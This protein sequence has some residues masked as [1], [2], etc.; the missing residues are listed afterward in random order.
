MTFVVLIP[1]AFAEWSDFV[2]KPIDNGVFVDLFSSYERD[3]IRTDGRSLVR[4]DT[5]LREKVT[6][7]SGGYFYHPRFLLYQVSLGGI[8]KQE[9][10]EATSL[11]EAGWKSGSGVEYDGRLLFLPEHPY[12]LELFARRFEPLF[13]E[14]SATQHNN[15]ETSRGAVFKYRQKPYFFHAQY[16][17]NVIESVSSSS[18]VQ[19]LGLGGEYFK[20]FE[21][22]NQFSLSAAYNPSRFSNSAGLD[23]RSTEKQLNHSFD[24]QRVNM[25]VNIVDNT[26]DQDSRA[27]GSYEDK[28]FDLYERLSVHLPHNFRTEISYRIRD[29]QARFTDPGAS[30]S[31]ELSDVGEDLQINVIHR[32]YQSLDTRYSFLRNTRDSSNGDISGLSH[33]LVTNYTKLIPNGR[34]M[35]GMHVGRSDTDNRGQADLVN[36]QHPATPVPGLFSLAQQNA[37]PGS[38]AVFLRSPLPPF[39]TVRLVEN[40]HY[41]VTVVTNTSQI[42]MLTLPPLFVVP[43]TYDL[44]VSYSLTTGDFELR[45]DTYG[46]NASVQLWNDLVTP[47]YSYAAVRSKEL[48]GTFPGIPLDSSTSIAGV[49]FHKGP[50]RARGE[51]QRVDWDVSP[52]HSWKGEVQVV[53][54]FD[55]STR[56]YLTAAYRNRR[57]PEGS[58]MQATDP[59]TEESESA[60]G[61]IQRQLFSRNMLVAAGGSVARIHGLV[62]STAYS[63]NSS[64]SWKIGKIDLSVGANAYTSDTDGIASVSTRRSDQY[65]YIKLRREFF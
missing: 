47:Y 41:T 10:Y 61:S 26:L 19:R 37:L 35:A 29:N 16:N 63:L 25:I 11:R 34:V 1:S 65:Y 53:K 56:L 8:L 33:S 3:E 6:V 48:D 40:V 30:G 42:N 9:E 39:Q 52:Y 49:M 28:Q 45:A 14:Q 20:R 58:S 21:S 55:S 31:R 4:T 18:N 60:S 13:K 51:Y 12:N 46:Y 24:T 38:I 62:G 22:G 57:F 64:V 15:V 43:G 54:A 7:F 27:S 59:Y 23:G 44:F 32:L 36:E 17:D 2:P 50:I 5:F